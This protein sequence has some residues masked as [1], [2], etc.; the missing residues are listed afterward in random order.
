MQV[1]TYASI[2][3]LAHLFPATWLVTSAKSQFNLDKAGAGGCLGLGLRQIG[4]VPAV[5][6]A[7]VV[8]QAGALGIELFTATV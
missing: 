6:G 4:R 5:W 8:R 3:G 2:F 7:L 1:N